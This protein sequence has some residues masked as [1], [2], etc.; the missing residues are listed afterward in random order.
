MARFSISSFATRSTGIR[1]SQPDG[2][3]YRAALGH[4]FESE[5]QVIFMSIPK[6]LEVLLNKF[7]PYLRGLSR[8]SAKKLNFFFRSLDFTLF[9]PGLRPRFSG[10]LINRRIQPRQRLGH[11]IY[12]AQI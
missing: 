5:L 2:L 7:Y 12:D 10:T 11:I 1:F 4:C 3:A 8:T 9:E 6:I